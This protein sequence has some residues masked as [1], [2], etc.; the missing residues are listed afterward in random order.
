MS[1]R[2]HEI[3]P[4]RS[5]GPCLVARQPIYDRGLEVFAYELLFRSAEGNGPGDVDG[6]AATS[7]TMVGALSEIGL[8]AIVGDRF[9]FVNA[10][11]RFVLDDFAPLFPSE[12]IGFELL[13]DVPVS[14]GLL[15]KLRELVAA[16]YVVALD[17][18]VY[19]DELRPLLDLARIVKLDVRELD[20]GELA[21]HVERLTP[22]RLKLLAEKVEDHETFEVCRE[23]GFDYFQGFFLSRPRTLA[24]DAIP[25][26]KLSRLR[27][28]AALHDPAVTLDQ[29]DALLRSDVGLSYRLLRLINSSFFYLPHKVHSIRQALV[30]LGERKLRKWTTV[31]VL[32]DLDDR[33]P[34]L[35]RIALVRARMCELLG[36]AGG[37]R[38]GS[39]CFVVGLFSLLDAFLDSP[40]EEILDRLPLDENVTAALR[41]RSGP[42]GELFAT[43]LAYEEG[44]FDELGEPHRADL[45]RTCYLDALAWAAETAPQPVARPARRAGRR[46]RR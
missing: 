42:L 33:P 35:T 4:A 3:V 14:P 46:A 5:C 39:S 30:L 34:E 8:D 31:L 18:F 13:E 43:V 36:E 37:R 24:G 11:A 7:R 1:D 20:R 6:D 32:A 15:A 12:R 44:R 17:D 16:G 22:L 9:G 41:D 25:T 27:L 10:T 28:L 21:D 45:L 2:A 19:R 26:P 23:L 40:L 29:L 38:D